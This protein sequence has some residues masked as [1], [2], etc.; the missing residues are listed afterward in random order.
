MTHP[1][2]VYVP[3][4]WRADYD[5]LRHQAGAYGESVARAVRDGY[6]DLPF[7]RRHAAAAIGFAEAADAALVA[8]VDDVAG[9]A[10][11]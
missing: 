4:P 10:A 3:A 8:Y 2:D 1:A 11:A 7:V 5:H 9:R 6:A